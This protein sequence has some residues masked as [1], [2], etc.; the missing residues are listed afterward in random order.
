MKTINMQIIIIQEISYFKIDGA[1]LTSFF[2]L[3]YS[4]ESFHTLIRPLISLHQR[5]FF[6]SCMSGHVSLLYDYV[7]KNFI[8][9]RR[10]VW[11]KK[12]KDEWGK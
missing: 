2:A 12:C 9:G 1:L 8:E 7:S 4:P 6:S 5:M 11:E 10:W 3:H